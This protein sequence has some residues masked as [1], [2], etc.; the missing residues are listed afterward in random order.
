M[1]RKGY[2]SV[3]LPDKVVEIIDKYRENHKT[4][5]EVK[6]TDSRSA[7]VREAIYFWAKQTGLISEENK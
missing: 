2:S 5:L 1:P 7:I 4:E 3:T 6:G